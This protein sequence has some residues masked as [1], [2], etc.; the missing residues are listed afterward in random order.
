M[1]W[2]TKTLY[3]QNYSVGRMNPHVL[4]CCT[5]RPGFKISIPWLAQWNVNLLERGVRNDNLKTCYCLWNTPNVKWTQ[6]MLREIRGHKHL[7]YNLQCYCDASSLKLV[8][9]LV[10]WGVSYVIFFT[11]YSRIFAI[12]VQPGTFVVVMPAAS[13][14]KWDKLC[15]IACCQFIIGKIILFSRIVSF[16]NTIDMAKRFV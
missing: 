10:D 6:I 9:R 3:C 15:N 7:L 4:I 1:A 13:H 12:F 14:M 2:R 11:D 8:I 5:S 16:I